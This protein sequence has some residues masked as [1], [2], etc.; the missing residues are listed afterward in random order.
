MRRSAVLKADDEA[1]AEDTPGGITTL[2]TTCMHA[3][4]MLI[5]YPICTFLA[6]S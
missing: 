1:L 2:S 6:R 4:F 5:S 3:A